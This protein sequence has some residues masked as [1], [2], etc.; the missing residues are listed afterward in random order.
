MVVDAA[1]G[2]VVE[3]RTKGA[4]EL[5]DPWTGSTRP[6]RVTEQTASP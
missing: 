4:V 1:P 6:L 5:W 3:F 2:T